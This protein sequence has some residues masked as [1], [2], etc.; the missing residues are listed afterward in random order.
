MTSST[1][2]GDGDEQAIPP[3][4][5]TQP[6]P[7]PSGVGGVGGASAAG[8]PTPPP[9]VAVG[10]P[11]PPGRLG[12]RATWIGLAA[13]G[14][15]VLAV[16]AFFAVNATVAG[17]AE[18]QAEE[19]ASAALGV[20]ANVRLQGFPVGIRLLLG[21]PVD[22]RLTARDVPLEGTE[23]TLTRLEVDAVNVVIERGGEG[24]LLAER[25]TFVAELDDDAVQ[26]LIGIVGRLPL[27]NIELANGVA[28]LSVA[29]FSL[30]DATADVE[31]GQVVFRLASPLGSLDFLG[32][33]SNVP[34]ELDALPL[35][36]EVTDVEIRRNL[37]RLRGS[38]TDLRL[39]GER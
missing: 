27:T 15:L 22:G 23:A 8:E 35:G 20:P 5:D 28:R 4:E 26:Q 21:A 30:I 36:F 19:E 14:L 16:I 12:R 25:A 3:R 2:P 11:P 37:L 6:I 38:A 17:N 32:R 7:L 1:P 18:R 13:A 33:F 24:A 10:E 34:L 29:G 9:G 31:A 39:E